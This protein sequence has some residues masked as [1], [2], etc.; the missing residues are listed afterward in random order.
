MLQCFPCVTNYSLTVTS[1]VFVMYSILA[2]ILILQTTKTLKGKTGQHTKLKSVQN[3][4]VAQT[5]LKPE[6]KSLGMWHLLNVCLSSF[7]FYHVFVSLMEC[8][9]LAI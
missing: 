8:I 5:P 1:V 2:K 6:V 9:L 7:C 4:R 3:K